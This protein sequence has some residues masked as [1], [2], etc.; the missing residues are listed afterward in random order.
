MMIR[1][2]LQFF[3][4]LRQRTRPVCP[5]CGSRHIGQE[6]TVDGMTTMEYH[7]GGPSGGSTAIQMHYSIT[8]QCNDCRAKW[9][10][11]ETETR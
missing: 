10:T 8:N 11:K 4:S 9:V 2:I 3:S 5:E 7:S 1:R 6:K